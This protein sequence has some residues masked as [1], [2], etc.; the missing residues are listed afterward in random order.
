MTESRHLRIKSESW[1]EDLKTI[2]EASPVGM[3]VFDDGEMVIY[4]NPQAEA[5]F[6]TRLTRPGNLR[7][8]DFINCA[9]RH[10]DPQ[11]CGHTPSCPNCPLF[12]AIRSALSSDQAPGIHAGDMQVQ[13]RSPACALWISYKAITLLRHHQQLSYEEIAETLQLPLGTVKARIH[14][15][16]SQIQQ[17]LAAR[18][19]D[20]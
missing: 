6:G 19:Y 5:L 20:I 9:N 4:A 11:G 16:R 13:R 1:Q 8:G 7:C 2:L 12:Q 18:S 14:R 15:A 17:M 3:V 10:T